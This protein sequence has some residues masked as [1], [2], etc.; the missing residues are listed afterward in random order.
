MP[1]YLL[2]EYWL[3]S[4]GHGDSTP[5]GPTREGGLSS[6]AAEDTAGA[7]E[8]LDCNEI[9]KYSEITCI[10]LESSLTSIKSSAT[11]GFLT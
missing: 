6:G 3:G 4:G 11:K 7:G 5:E 1:S 2:L 8:E 9:P 10:L